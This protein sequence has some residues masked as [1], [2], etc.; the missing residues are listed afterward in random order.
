[1]KSTRQ[2][3]HNLDRALHWKVTLNLKKT[4]GMLIARG[5]VPTKMKKSVVQSW[6]KEKEISTKNAETNDEKL[7]T[8]SKFIIAHYKDFYCKQTLQ[9]DGINSNSCTVDKNGAFLARI[10]RYVNTETCSHITENMIAT[11]ATLLITSKT[12]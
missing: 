7:S 9:K 10:C 6:I 12:C 3:A 1:M 11:S 2:P 5:R 8:Q 4:P